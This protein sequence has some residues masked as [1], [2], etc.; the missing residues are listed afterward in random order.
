MTVDDDLRRRSAQTLE[1]PAEQRLHL[2]L[3]KIALAKLDEPHTARDRPLHDVHE[4]PPPRLPAI[5]HEHET[6]E[7]ARV[8]PPAGVGQWSGSGPAWTRPAQGLDASA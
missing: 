8:L 2:G 6:G 4:I 7:L 5:G 3:G 1:Q